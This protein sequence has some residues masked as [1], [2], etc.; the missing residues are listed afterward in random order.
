MMNK[1]MQLL[2]DNAAA[3]RK[4]LALVR[5]DACTDATLYVYDVIDSFWGVSAQMVAQAIAGLGAEVTLHVRINSPGGDVFEARAMKSLLDQCP[6]RVVTHIDGL[7]ASAATTVALAGDEI[8][9]A[10]GAYFMIHNAWSIAIGSKED[11]LDMAKLLEKMDGT[12]GADYA[13]K[14]GLSLA[15]VATLMDEETWM[16]AQEALDAGFVD[17]IAAAVQPTAPDAAPGSDPD[18]APSAKWNLA[19]YDKTPKA[20][21][22]RPAPPAPDL[23]AIHS[24]NRRRL[25]LLEIA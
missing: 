13:Q 20:L 11:M 12:I 14:T 24:N 6:C 25:R 18:C 22:E 5:A 17:K 1:L 23:A 16:T 2:R 8:V 4:P 7:A 10:E 9:M 3:E 15:A 19:A 21:T